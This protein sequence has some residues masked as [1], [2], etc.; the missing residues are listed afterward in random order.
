MGFGRKQLPVCDVADPAD[1]SDVSIK[2]HIQVVKV[3]INYRFG[4]GPVVARY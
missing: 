3:G 1:C 2:Q 4:P